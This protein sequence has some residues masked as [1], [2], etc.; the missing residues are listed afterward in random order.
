[1]A[2]SARNYHKATKHNAAVAVGVVADRRIAAG[3][4]ADSSG[5]VTCS[6]TSSPNVAPSPITYHPC[7]RST[8]RWTD[9]F[10]Y[11]HIYGT[12]I[13][14]DAAAV[15]TTA[16]VFSFFS[17]FLS[18]ISSRFLRREHFSRRGRGAEEKRSI[19]FRALRVATIGNDVSSI[20]IMLC[21]E[22]SRAVVV[23]CHV[24]ETTHTYTLSRLSI[25]LKHTGMLKSTDLTGALAKLATAR[26]SC[27]H[28]N[29]VHQSTCDDNKDRLARLTQLR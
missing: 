15:T 5:T 18:Q 6:K 23:F 4:L 25:R 2:S 21:T 16:F 17:I 20:N 26:A 3:C 11:R 24:R 28:R 9:V 13:L 10:A 14:S 12:T 22:Y 7:A 29:L 27:V 19:Y 1:M 8:P